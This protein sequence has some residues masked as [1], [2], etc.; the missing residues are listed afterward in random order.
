MKISNFI[1]LNSILFLVACDFMTSKEL[2]IELQSFSPKLSVTAILNGESGIFD[3][4]IMEGKSLAEPYLYNVDIICNGEIRLYEN[5]NLILSIPGPFDMSRK[6]TNHGDGW[7][8]GQNGY[9]WVS[10]GFNTNPGSVYHLE[11][12]IDGYPKAV[13]TTVM[14]EAP[15]V[16][17]S[18]DTSVQVIRKNV[19][20][21]GAAGFF[22]FQLGTPWGGNYP[23]KYWPLS[24]T[25]NL[26]DANNYFILD[27]IKYEHRDNMNIGQFRGIGASDMLTLIEYGIGRMGNERTDLFLFSMLMT[28]FTF[29][30][31]NASRNYYAAVIDIPNNPDDDL[32]LVENPDMEKIT[33]QHSLNLR[34]RNISSATYKYFQGMSFQF[35]ESSG[36]FLSEEQPATVVGNIEGGYGIFSVYNTTSIPLLEWETYEYRKK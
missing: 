4:R 3:I 22:L 24:V 34:I 13:S 1:L 28:N 25:V 17:A 10:D 11:V 26:R 21:I 33:S 36:G 8:W 5:D 7:T 35:T 6:I 29:S 16:S 18:M 30:E 9:R 20:E 31:K 15:V 14:P 12:D 32:F 27:I 23:D 2:D 19:V